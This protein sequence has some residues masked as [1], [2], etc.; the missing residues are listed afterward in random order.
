[1]RI[2]FDGTAWVA[3]SQIYVTNDEVPELSEAFA[4]QSN[5]LCGAA[6]P[7]VLFLMTGT[8]DGR[9]RFTV[10][11]HDQQPPLPGE[12]WQDVVEVSFVPG[13][14]AV[15]LLQWSGSSAARLELADAGTDPDDLA[16]F[17]VQYCAT[18]MDLGHDP[19]GGIDPDS[20]ADGDTSY[21]DHRPDRYLLR[22]W[23]DGTEQPR[24]DAVLRHTSSAATYW[25]DWA[26]K[27]PPPPTAEERAAAERREQEVQQRRL[28]ELRLREEARVWGG[29]PPGERL[30]QVGGNIHQ[31]VQYDRDLVDG[32]VEASAA[33][34]RRIAHWAA[35]RAY[36]RAGITDLE[37][38]APAWAALERGEPLPVD[39]T[40]PA[41][42]L[43]R[44]DG[45]P[46]VRYGKASVRYVGERRFAPFYQAA[47]PEPPEPRELIAAM[48]RMPSNPVPMA[49]PAL[50]AAAGP[51]PLQAALEAV[52]YALTTYGPLAETFVAELR[53]AF[54]VTDQEGPPR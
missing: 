30:R 34:Q 33:T 36:T 21:M 50:P 42:M 22:F 27:L 52:W 35:R 45:G 8:H 23:P 20:I 54:P 14:P 28:E 25:H 44:I 26:R 40:D 1:M 5:G 39:C 51:D 18:G 3:Y 48:L 37:W 19:F 9:V 38:L 12:E 53:R 2:L 4:G 7:G 15:E 32:I 13:E 41:A 16:A 10:E 29:R 17:R 24:P 31:L 11:L 49:L 47:W 46:V 6:T 43:E